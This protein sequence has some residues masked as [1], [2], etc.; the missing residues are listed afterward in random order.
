MKRADHGGR[1]EYIVRLVAAAPPLS[2]AQRD[3]LA[4]LLR[5]AASER[6]AAR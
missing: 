3:R 4:V 2:A 5:P 6:A 1:A